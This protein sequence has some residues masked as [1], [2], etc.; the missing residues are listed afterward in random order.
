M[1]PHLK[2]AA[3]VPKWAAL[4]VEAV[5]K[6]GLIMEAYRIHT[7]LKRISALQYD[8]SIRVRHLN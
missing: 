6:P 2:P 7:I 8:L 4:L 3:D 5:N 1:K